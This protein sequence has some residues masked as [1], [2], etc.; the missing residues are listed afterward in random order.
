M[1]EMALDRQ[2]G[3]AGNRG[4]MLHLVRLQRPANRQRTIV[5]K[6][7]VATQQPVTVARSID[8]QSVISKGLSDGDSV[9]TAGHLLLSNGTKVTIREAKASL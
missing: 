2:P 9:V 5:V 6:D 3:Q 7:G 4:Q 8:G 1:S